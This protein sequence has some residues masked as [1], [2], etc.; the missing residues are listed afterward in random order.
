[1]P[2]C[3]Q[4]H[5]AIHSVEFLGAFEECV[6]VCF[7]VVARDLKEH[8]FA[9]VGTQESVLTAVPLASLLPKIKACTERLLPGNLDRNPAALETIRS[10][11]KGPHCQS[12]CLSIFDVD[13]HSVHTAAVATPPH[14]P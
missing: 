10:Q 2:A 14:N 5:R 8:G 11:S 3:L 9:A 12:L 4:T 6:R 13:C 7:Y 1:L